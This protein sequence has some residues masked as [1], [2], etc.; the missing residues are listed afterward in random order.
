MAAVAILMWVVV[1]FRVGR[2]RV[3]HE[4]VSGRGSLTEGA[5]WLGA[6]VTVLWLSPHL[7]SWFG[8]ANL[9]ALFLRY[10]IGI[11]WLRVRGF[12]ETMLPNPGSEQR[13]MV[14]SRTCWLGTGAMMADATILWWFFLPHDR[15]LVML[16]EV[17]GWPTTAL[18][19]GQYAW[20]LAISADAMRIGVEAMRSRSLDLGTRTSASFVFLTGAVGAVGAVEMT[21]ARL[22]ATGSTAVPSTDVLCPIAGVTFVGAMVSAPVVERLEQHVIARREIRRLRPE[23]SAVVAAYPEVILPLSRSQR[24][25]DAPVVAERMRIEILDARSQVSRAG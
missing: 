19:V 7:S 11:A 22:V 4:S 13:G 17:A 24:W 23:Y 10:T 15:E 8:V 1:A 3:R 9:R 12:F 5:A 16:N 18:I 20:L 25:L 2:S 14:R 21:A 6:T